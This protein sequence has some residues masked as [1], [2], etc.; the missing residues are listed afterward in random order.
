MLAFF[1]G[2]EDDQD[3]GFFGERGFGRCNAD[4][5]GAV[6]FGLFGRFDELVGTISEASSYEC[7]RNSYVGMG[8]VDYKMAGSGVL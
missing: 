4:D 1:V 5:G 8:C 2:V 7:I 3:V 6:G